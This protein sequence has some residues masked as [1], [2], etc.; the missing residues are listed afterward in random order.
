M[1]T[2]GCEDV[3]TLTEATR[4][5]PRRRRRRPVNVSTLHRWATR[6]L[7]GVHL[8]TIQVG[9]TKCTSRE[10]LQRF[11]DALPSASKQPG[12]GAPVSATNAGA[13]ERAVADLEG[14]GM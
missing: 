7:R 1:I 8:E 9:G 13:V 6:G 12:K 3:M 10:A 2:V 4:I 11:F 14:M 5:L